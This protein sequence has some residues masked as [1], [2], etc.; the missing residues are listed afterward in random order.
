MSDE[1]KKRRPVGRLL[2]GVFIVAAL[3]AAA[4]YVLRRASAE[5]YREFD[6][7]D[8]SYKVVVYRYPSLSA[9]PGQSGDAPGFVRLYD[10]QG[11]PLAEAGVEMVQLADR[12]EWERDRVSIRL[13]AEWRL[14]R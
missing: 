10:R 12:V 1:E 8:G 11:R 7:P 4:L 9:M 5:V 3:A 6:S 14:P 13:V 2:L